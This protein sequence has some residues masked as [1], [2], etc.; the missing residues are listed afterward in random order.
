M[1]RTHEDTV[2]VGAP[3]VRSCAKIAQGRS[4]SS[5]GDLFHQRFLCWITCAMWVRYAGA[6][7]R[8]ANNFHSTRQLS[9]SSSTE[10]YGSYFPLVFFDVHLSFLFLIFPIRSTTILPN[11]FV[12]QFFPSS[13]CLYTKT[14]STSSSSIMLEA[15]KRGTRVFRALDTSGRGRLEYTEFLAGCTHD[16]SI[17]NSDDVMWE[18]FRHFVRRLGKGSKKLCVEDMLAT[19]TVVPHDGGTALS[20]DLERVRGEMREDLQAGWDLETGGKQQLTYNEFKNVMVYGR[21]EGEEIG[22]G[23]SARKKRKCKSVSTQLQAGT[24]KKGVGAGGG[25]EEVG[26]VS[27]RPVVDLDGQDLDDYCSPQQVVRIRRKR[28]VK[29]FNTCLGISSQKVS[30]NSRTRAERNP[31]EASPTRKKRSWSE[32]KRRIKARLLLG[33]KR[34]GMVVSS[35]CSP[36]GGGPMQASSCSPSCAGGVVWSAPVSDKSA[37]SLTSVRP[38]SVDSIADSVHS[39]LSS[40]T[41]GQQRR[42]SSGA[43]SRG[44]GA[45]RSQR[46]S[47]VNNSTSPECEFG[48]SIISASDPAQFHQHW[49]LS[50]ADNLSASTWPEARNT[51]GN[52]SGGTSDPSRGHHHDQPSDRES[53]ATGIEMI[54]PLDVMN[55]GEDCR[56]KRLASTDTLVADAMAT[57]LPRDNTPHATSPCASPLFVGNEDFHQFDRFRSNANVPVRDSDG[58]SVAVSS[59]F[60]CDFKPPSTGE[61]GGEGGFFSEFRPPTEFNPPQTPT[62]DERGGFFSDFKPPPTGRTPPATGFFS[63]FPQQP[64]VEASSGFF[65]EFVG[66]AVRGNNVPSHQEGTT[67]ARGGGFFSEFRLPESVPSTDVVVDRSGAGIPNS[68]SDSIPP[69]GFFSEFRLPTVS[70][71]DTGDSSR[72]RTQEEKKLLLQLPIAQVAA[73]ETTFA[74]PSLE[75]PIPSQEP[76]PRDDAL[77]ENSI[78]TVEDHLLQHE[79]AA[80]D[81]FDEARLTADFQQEQV[82]TGVVRRCPF[83][84]VNDVDDTVRPLSIR[85]RAGPPGAD[86]HSNTSSSQHVLVEQP[87]APIVRRRMNNDGNDENSFNPYAPNAGCSKDDGGGYTHSTQSGGA[88][89]GSSSTSTRTHSLSTS[90]PSRTRTI[91]GGTIVSTP[92]LYKNGS[93]TASIGVTDEYL[94]GSV[95]TSLTGEPHHGG[96]EQATDSVSSG[97][98]TGGG[99]WDSSSFGRGGGERRGGGP[100][101]SSSTSRPRTQSAVSRTSGVGTSPNSLQSFGRGLPRLA[102]TPRHADG[103]R[104]SNIGATVGGPRSEERFRK[105]EKTTSAKEQGSRFSQVAA[106]EA[107]GGAPGAQ[108]DRGTTP[109]ANGGA[110]GNTAATRTTHDD[111]APLVQ[112]IMPPR[113]PRPTWCSPR[114]H[115]SYRGAPPDPAGALQRAFGMPY[116]EMLRPGHHDV[117]GAGQQSKVVGE[118]WSTPAFG[119]AAL[120]APGEN[121]SVG[122]PSHRTSSRRPS[123]SPKNF[124]VDTGVDKVV[125]DQDMTK[126]GDVVVSSSRSSR[127]GCTEDEEKPRQRDT[128]STGRPTRQSRGAA[129]EKSSSP[130]TSTRPRRTGLDKT[131]PWKKTKSSSD[132]VS[133]SAPPATPS[134]NRSSRGST[135]SKR[136][137]RSDDQLSPERRREKNTPAKLV[138]TTT[139]APT[140]Q[141][142]HG[143]AGGPPPKPNPISVAPTTTPTTLPCYPD[144]CWKQRKMEESEG[145]WKRKAMLSGTTSGSTRAATDMSAMRCSGRSSILS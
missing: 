20:A 14:E 34:S 87:V 60:F 93:R 54:D 47:V 138:S 124:A 68:T 66:Q 46:V 36:R 32:E 122:E 76:Q 12:P 40:P 57:N 98:T 59:G 133:K 38:R 121:Y 45:V 58:D 28:R 70:Q 113:H 4:S 95:T 39:V 10:N 118:V 43:A 143:G 33:I 100:E 69:C 97:G 83:E 119:S 35:V 109:G 90:T 136:I 11:T 19:L 81:V 8:F 106:E 21:V 115:S 51:T 144:S 25:G 130:S 141:G 92:V 114:N 26:L 134:S 37:D 62:I 85:G 117:D 111:G 135:W 88:T 116:S 99:A 128:T 65:S 3:K 29:R 96:G 103:R 48:M 84:V 44:R 94:H 18:V 42:R 22:V 49:I 15:K 61:S 13:Y 23:G 6:P 89:L 75:L 74:M 7:T 127:R 139:T 102:L 105:P 77:F 55:H 30:S 16:L 145:G 80:Q 104:R 110:P 71:K 2:D 140:A 56:S 78:R 126:G 101:W 41:P 86:Q 63:E 123:S 50:G 53:S 17:L 72:R 120:G 1:G 132:G 131:K 112:K 125:V 67:P 31:F 27:S 82:A 9:T 24:S 5:S 52:I 64:F 142:P 73:P 137:R 108:H 91:P 129:G 107:N 79:R